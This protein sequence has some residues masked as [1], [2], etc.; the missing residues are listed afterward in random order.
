MPTYDYLC[1]ACARRVEVVHGVHEL[2]PVTCPSCGAQGTL[3]KAFV[4]PTIHFRGSGWAKKERAGVRASS[5]K[6]RDGSDSDG[7]G[8]TEGGKAEPA[9]GAGEPAATKAADD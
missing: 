8:P 3:R 9:S 2:G 4:P 1:A 5:R 6:A 7:K